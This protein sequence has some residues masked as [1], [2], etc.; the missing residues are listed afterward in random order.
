[1]AD[2][3]T[4]HGA[5]ANGESFAPLGDE[6]H[7][8]GAA[9]NL[10]A[11][12]RRGAEPFDTLLWRLQSRPSA[13]AFDA[14]TVGLVGCGERVGVTTLAANLAV[15]AC[16]LGM[17][18]VL[19]VEAETARPKLRKA[20]R[21]PA[22]PGLAEALRGEADFASCVL[23]GPAVGLKVICAS[24]RRLG[25]LTWYAGAVD[26]LLA[27]ACADHRLAL[28]DLAA[29]GA[30]GGARALAQRL[31]QVLLVVDAESTR[32]NVAERIAEGLRE[33]GV[34][35]TGAVLNRERRYA[36]RWLSRWI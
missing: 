21:L 11:K 13:T 24:G 8:N 7:R 34:P 35:I 2:A 10:A 17:G 36:P 4:A 16:E 19:L 30:L 25:A 33:D 29:A 1:M 3:F 12:A 6:A 15:R 31:D 28:F 32:G 20:W 18:P 9:I 27:E 23:P 26:A 5:H 22:G 14:T